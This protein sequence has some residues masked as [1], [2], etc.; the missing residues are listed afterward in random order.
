MIRNGR[1][2]IIYISLVHSINIIRI[3]YWNWWNG[4]YI[5]AISSRFHSDSEH[6]EIFRTPV[7]VGKLK[8]RREIY[9]TWKTCLKAIQFSWTHLANLKGT[10]WTYCYSI[11]VQPSDSTFISCLN[12]I[13][14]F[15]WRSL[16][17]FAISRA[18]VYKY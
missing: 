13:Y 12:L 9:F 18:A 2:I 5:W 3:L 1:L 15:S 17:W 6:I 4:P 10:E 8:K 14:V 11:Q 16:M 7:W